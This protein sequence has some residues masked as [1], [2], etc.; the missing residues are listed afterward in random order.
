MATSYKPLSWGEEYISSDKLNQMASNDQY[1]FERTPTVYYSAYGVNKKSG[2]MKIMSGVLAIYAN[3]NASHVTKDYHFGS[4]FSHG[5]RPVITVGQNMTTAGRYH[6]YFK[7]FGT[8]APDHRGVKFGVIANH[9]SG[10]KTP[11]RINTK[12]Y[13]HWTAVGW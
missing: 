6:V 7:G 1:L 2:G 3:K 4:F 13:I 8:F 5:C 12:I 9:R 11:N 10:S